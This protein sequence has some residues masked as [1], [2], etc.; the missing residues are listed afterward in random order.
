MASPIEDMIQDEFGGTNEVV[1]GWVLVAT[2]IQPDGEGNEVY[3]LRIRTDGVSQ[4]HSVIGL[5]RAG[6]QAVLRALIE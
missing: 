6:E 5:L 1:T 3:G 4:D 2:T